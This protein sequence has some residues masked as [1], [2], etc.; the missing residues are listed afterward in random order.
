MIPG[1]NICILE[2]QPLRGLI[3][4][5]HFA[6]NILVIFGFFLHT[7]TQNTEC[8]F[9]YIEVRILIWLIRAR[10]PQQKAGKVKLL[11][12]GHSADTMSYI[13]GHFFGPIFNSLDTLSME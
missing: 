9:M 4:V 5:T 3:L 6:L 8:S 12:V 1:R 2:F 11:T 13:S 7:Q 10:K